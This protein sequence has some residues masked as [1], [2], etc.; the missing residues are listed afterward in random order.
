MSV[1]QHSLITDRQGEIFEYIYQRIYDGQ[2]PSVRE[3]GEAFDIKSPNGVMCHLKALVRKGVI[4]MAETQARSIR[5]VSDS[6]KARIERLNALNEKLAARVLVLEKM[7]AQA[8]FTE[9]DIL[10]AMLNQFQQPNQ[11][12]AAAG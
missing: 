9:D 8:G 11:E 2:P 12:Q 3:I 1:Q 6:P 5:L 10:N 7:L 4:T